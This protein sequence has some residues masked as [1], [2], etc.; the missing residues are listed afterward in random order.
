MEK[1]RLNLLF[2][3]SM[4]KTSGLFWDVIYAIAQ[5]SK[6]TEDFK[7]KLFDPL[8]EKELRKILSAASLPNQC[9]VSDCNRN[10]H[11]GLPV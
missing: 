4:D 10:S 6:H 2:L 1:N 8:S 3:L 11:S 7:K 5:E 9:L